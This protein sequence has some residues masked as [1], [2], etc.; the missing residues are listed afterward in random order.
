M[1]IQ[2]KIFPQ[3][4]EPFAPLFRFIDRHG[5]I[6]HRPGQFVH[7][8]TMVDTPSVLCETVY[9]RDESFGK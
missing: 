1:A 5:W 4:R 9:D 8:I 2:R 3:R 6:P 7:S